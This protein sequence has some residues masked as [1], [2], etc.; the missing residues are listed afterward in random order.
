MLI[1]T[2]SC[3]PKMRQSRLKRLYLQIGGVISRTPPLVKAGYSKPGE[4]LIL[5][6][7]D[8]MR[9]GLGSEIYIKVDGLDECPE[10]CLATRQEFAQKLGALLQRTV[11]QAK[12]NC[13][14][15]IPHPGDGVWNSPPKK[16]KKK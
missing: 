2:V 4:T 3:L 1:V 16:K 13:R 9:F 12:I 8:S 6:P 15:T 10:C 14:V 7:P 5:F 11:P